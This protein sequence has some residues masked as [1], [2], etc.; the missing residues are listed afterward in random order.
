MSF[1]LFRHYFFSSR[2]GSL[3]RV[4]FWICLAGL[5]VSLASLILI[6]SIMG[7]LGEAT[8]A[9]L[10]SKTAH[11]ILHFEENPFLKKD[12]PSAVQKKSLFLD[13]EDLSGLFPHLTQEQKKGIQSISIY[14]SQNLILKS[15]N[16]FKGIL[17]IGYSKEQ[18]DKKAKQS[19]FLLPNLA[20][21]PSSPLGQ[22][23]LREI[24]L[25]NSLFLE[26]GLDPGEEL[27]LI[28]LAGLLLPPSLLPP[29]KNFKIKGIV[30]E[31]EEEP[32]SIYY[33]QGEMDFGVF[34]QVNYRAKLQLHDPYQASIYQELFKKDKVQTWMERNS[35]H[36]FALQLEKF[37]MSLFMMIALLISFLGL[38]STLSFLIA[39]KKEDLAILYAMGLSRKEIVQIWTRLGLCLSSLG[40]LLGL[41]IGLGGTAFLKYN[42]SIPILPEMYQDRTLPAVFMPGNFL[43]VF[44]IAGG[45]AWLF[46]YL[47]AKYLSRL[48]PAELLKSSAF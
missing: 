3:V 11:L 14:E 7:G 31:S 27:T 25:S 26:T 32:F 28:P 5:A 9:R 24:L 20:S 16:T 37:I 23:S 21:T 18:W 12:L 22:N 15:A 36:F 41:L 33:K 30:E 19:N 43:M 45:L 10:L 40:L 48:Q 1:Y 47:P 13:K 35:S 8:K 4:V 44:L 46:C 6:L 42:K 38:S 17:A 2:T 39:Q 34:S 29:V